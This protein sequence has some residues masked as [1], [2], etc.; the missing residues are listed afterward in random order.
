MKRLVLLGLAAMA[1]A[2]VL[3]QRPSAVSDPDPPKLFLANHGP[4][5]PLAPD[6]LAPSPLE[7]RE[8]LLGEALFADPRLSG[9]ARRACVSC[10]DVASNGASTLARDATPDGGRLAVNTPTVFNAASNFRLNW[11]GASRSLAEQARASIQNPSIMNGDLVEAARRLGADPHAVRQFRAAYQRDP[12]PDDILRALARYESTLRTPNSRFDR[13]LQG[14]K[15]ALSASE[16]RGYR[17]FQSAGCSS[18]HQGANLGGNLFQ[19]SGVFH[20]LAKTG[21]PTLRVPSLRNVAA[22]APYFH[23][24]SAATL[25]EAVHAMGRAQLN[26][27]LSDGQAADIAAFLRTLTGDYRGRPVTSRKA[28]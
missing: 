11:T 8:I 13:Y 24:G 5:S 22:T 17:L 6:P 2:A 14:E 16:Q 4:F 7:M 9:D 28:T 26:R 27:V 18:C 23:D 3:V 12:N 10:H 15:G 21:S 20:P 19:R 1:M 25:E